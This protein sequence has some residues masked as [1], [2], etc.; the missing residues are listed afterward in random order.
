[1]G[2]WLE[3][4]LFILVLRGCCC[5]LFTIEVERFA[6]R[7]NSIP[8]SQASNNYT[9]LMRE[10]E[11]I[12]INFC[13]RQTSTVTIINIV[14][15][16]DGPSDEI[17]ATLDGHNMG[18]F[19][20]SPYEGAGRGWNLF[21]SSG[22]LL[23]RAVMTTGPHVLVLNVTRSDKYGVEIDNVF[24][25]IDDYGLDYPT[26]FCTLYCFDI[27]YNNTVEQKLPIQNGKFVQKSSSSQCAEADNVKVEIFHNTTTDFEITA[28]IPKYLSFA[29]YR[30][31]FFDSCILGSPYW[32]FHNQ[33][34]TQRNEHVKTPHATLRLQK[35]VYGTVLTVTFDLQKLS[36]V[37]EVDEAKIGG[38]LK[39]KLRNMPRENV[40]VKPERMGS[41]GQWVKMTDMTFTPF[42]TLRTWTIP[43]FSWSAEQPNQVKLKIS[44]GKQ[45]VVVDTLLLHRR[46]TSD[47]TFDV[48]SDTNVVIQGVRLGFWHHWQD[49]PQSMTLQTLE[50]TD[51]RTELTKIDSLRIYSKVPWTGGYSQVFVLFQDGRIRIQAI[52]PHGLDYIPFGASVNIGQPLNTTSKRPYSAIKT[53]NIDPKLLQMII[54]YE[55]GNSATFVLKTTFTETKLV[56]TRGRFLLN[57]SQFPIMTF[58]SMWM[59]DGNSDTD[60]VTINGGK[61]RHI[62]SDWNELPGKS[63]AFFR[64]CISRHNT[65]A[66][67][68]RIQFL[69]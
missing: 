14:Y 54:M 58:Q 21:R 59:N 13:L 15:S 1:M 6:P 12:R 20:G 41:G 4:F 40:I 27:N 33:S 65:Q 43:D 38:I 51:R 62:M 28:N 47:R 69:N 45:G 7:E 46:A 52:T 64:K 56:V 61:A 68:I 36:P 11:T 60:H 53:I 23:G 9:V 34:L 55:N 5:K 25:N 10:Y 66:P 39:L 3:N 24:L 22:R 42:S 44:H 8:R 57:R 49:H 17:K 50:M 37:R 2:R 31:P 30:D 32:A 48:Y 63:A 26:L 19:V 35:A 18:S 67:D 16:N 29:N